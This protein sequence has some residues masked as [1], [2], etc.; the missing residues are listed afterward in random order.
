[1]K[2]SDVKQHLQKIE[3]FRI[4]LPNGSWLPAHFHISEVGISSKHFVDCGGVVRT[5]QRA[6][7]QL[8]QADDFDHRLLP[9][10]FHKII[11]V[12]EKA[13]NMGNLEVEVEYQGN[14]IEKYGLE[15]GEKGF[16]L[17]PTFTD[18]LA[19]GSCGISEP[20]EKVSLSSLGEGSSNACAPGSGCC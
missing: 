8:Y 13:L 5:E 15:A 1:M 10:K 16:L 7:F 6:N 17:T 3:E 18:C 12:S 20:K 9:Q 4:Q 14:T 2:L 11:E 19:K